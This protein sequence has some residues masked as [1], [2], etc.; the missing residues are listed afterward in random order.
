LRSA[1]KP[2]KVC[3]GKIVKAFGVKGWVKVQ[4]YSTPERFQLLTRVIIQDNPFKVDGVSLVKGQVLLKLGGIDSRNQGQELAGSF[5]YLPFEERVKLPEGHY[6]VDDLKTCTVLTTNGEAVGEL[7]EIWHL[8]SNDVFLVQ[9]PDQKTI[10]VPALKEI[11]K[12]IDLQKRL[13]IVEEWGIV[14]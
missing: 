4:A 13:I 14:R 6:F 9:G 12:T 3:I 7:V 11:I 2:E 10:M 1:E 8:P 5:L